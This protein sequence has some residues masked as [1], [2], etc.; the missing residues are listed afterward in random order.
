MTPAPPLAK[1]RVL[2][3]EDD[4]QNV[5]VAQLRLGKRY[6]LLVATD[7]RSAIKALRENADSLAAV[8]MDVELQ[9]STLDGVKLTRLL[10]GTLPEAQTPD[11][12]RN[13]PRVKAPIFIVTAYVGQYPMQH[14]LDAGADHFFSKPVDFVKLSLALATASTRAALSSLTAKPG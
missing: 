12:A 6:E 2:Y 13:M 4:P 7:D 9:G 11:Y 5:E 8:L 3:V 10:R 14:M 1:P